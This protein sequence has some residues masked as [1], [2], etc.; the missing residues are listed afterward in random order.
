MDKLLNLLSAGDHAG[1]GKLLRNDLEPA[2]LRKFPLLAK[3]AALLRESGG[4]PL[5]SG[6]GSTMFALYPDFKLRDRACETLKS[7]I[8]PYNAVLIKS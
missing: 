3:F 4:A 2:A 5:M 6:S 8:E 7:Q 1:A